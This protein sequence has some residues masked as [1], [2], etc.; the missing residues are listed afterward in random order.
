MNRM[1][2]PIVLAGLAAV[3]VDAESVY[4]K[5]ATVATV[6]GSMILA[7]WYMRGLF[8]RHNTSHAKTEKAIEELTTRVNT[9]QQTLEVISVDLGPLRESHGRSGGANKARG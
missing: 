5:L 3:G 6:S 8:D 7:S 4:V 2:V 1:A 9:M